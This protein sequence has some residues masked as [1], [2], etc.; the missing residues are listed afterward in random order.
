MIKKVLTWLGIA[1]L[2]FFI[3]FRWI[4]SPRCS[5]NPQVHRFGIGPVGF[6]A[7]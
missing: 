5:T 7:I 4:R 3:A 6:A 2:I 1:F